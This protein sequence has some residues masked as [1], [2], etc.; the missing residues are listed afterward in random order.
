MADIEAMFHQVKVTPDDRDVL[1]F[2]WFQEDNTGGQSVTYRMTPHLFGGVWS[3]SCANYALQQT[4][5]IA[6]PHANQVM[7]L[8]T[9]RGFHLTNLDKLPTEHALGMLW[10]I[11]SGHFKF[12]IGV[13]KKPR[14]GMSL[15]QR[16]WRNNG[17]GG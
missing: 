3:P 15:C 6:V 10:D 2:L 13:K 9:K 7:Q 5:E 8:L 1:R 12:D 17:A 14:D 16:T 11:E 4:L